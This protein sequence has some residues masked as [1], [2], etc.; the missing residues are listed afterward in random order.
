MKNTTYRNSYIIAALFFAL[1]FA[2]CMFLFYFVSYEGSGFIINLMRMLSFIFA[3]V[4]LTV[5]AVRC[6]VTGKIKNPDKFDPPRNTAYYL[7]RVGSIVLMIFLMSLAASL[8][9]MVIATFFGGIF[10]RVNNTFFS[11][12]LL[13][14]PIFALYL[15]FVYKMLVRFGFMDSQ[16]KV[17]NPNLKTLSFIIAFILLMPSLVCSNYFYAPALATD[18][19]MNVQTILSP[20]YG[21]YITEFDGL[22]VFRYINEDF[23]VSNA[24]LI[25]TT[26][27]LT[28]II[29]LFFFRFAYYRGKKIFIKQHIR[30]VDEYAMD[31]N[32]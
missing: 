21:T 11:E 2:L 6:A 27:L 19:S 22:G 31:E 14:L 7:K 4:V 29:Q 18:G 9:G 23:A 8:V 30:Q 20:C 3:G 13:K 10:Y 26:V 1:L 28:F 24:V 32:L 17:F 16:R 25:G 15:S 12:F 5:T